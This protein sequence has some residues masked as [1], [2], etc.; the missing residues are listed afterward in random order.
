MRRRY[1]RRLAVL[2]GVPSH[3]LANGDN[4]LDFDGDVVRQGA[5]ANRQARMA[6]SVAEYRNEQIRRAVD[7]LGLAGELGAGV[8]EPGNADA[9]LNAVEVAIQ[10]SMHVRDEVQGA[11]P[12][13]PPPV[14]DAEIAAELTY[15]PALAVPLGELRREE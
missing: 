11:D 2:Q 4:C 15:V 5:N 12:S 6:T 1:D 14:L 9:P 8:D 13:G 10:C 3:G 7:Y